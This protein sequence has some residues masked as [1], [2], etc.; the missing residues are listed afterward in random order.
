MKE[1]KEYI[2][3]EYELVGVYKKEGDWVNP[4]GK[5]LHYKF[6]CVDIRLESGLV[7]RARVDRVFNDYVEE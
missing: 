4:E 6:Y 5:E 1:E 2:D 3:R 7:I